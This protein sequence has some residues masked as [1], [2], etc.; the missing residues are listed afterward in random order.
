MKIEKVAI[1]GR[2]ALGILYGAH[3]TEKLGKQAVSFVASEDR[4]ERYMSSQPVCN[5]RACDF[6]YI[7]E[8]N[9]GNPA[10][11]VIFAV[12]STKL[13]EALKTAKNVIGEDT[14]IISVLNGISSEKIIASEYGSARII[15]CVAQGMD[16]VK[17]GDELT[18]SKMGELIVGTP[19]AEKEKLER[20]E[21]LCSFFEQTQLP[22]T[23][24]ENIIH[25]MWSKFMLNVGVNQV[26]MVN[27]GTYRT[28]QQPGEA[29]EMMIEAMREVIKL[30]EFEGA[31][32][33]E[34]ELQEYV[35]L[36]DTLHPDKMP[37]MRQDGIEK[38]RSEVE[39]FSGTVI[40]LSEENGIKSP[41]NEMLYRR[42]K[43]IESSY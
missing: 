37:S 28:I 39:L 6:S 13:E 18:Y 20:L 21:A 22:Y 23:R 5:G 19:E 2:G 42:I 1:V 11:L 35:D 26:V 17:L 4:I 12:K 24:D 43:E 7:S 38:R 32:V 3:F 33:T 36:V 41:V 30:S 29:R 8:K 16:A 34:K 9:E 15:H 27:E 10:D 40:R 14:V 25:R 31:G